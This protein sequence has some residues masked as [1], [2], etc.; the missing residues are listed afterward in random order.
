MNFPWTR[1]AWALL[2]IIAA[3]GWI[4]TGCNSS[5]TEVT[6]KTSKYEVADAEG[7]SSTSAS[8][9]NAGSNPGVGGSGAAAGS[10]ADG[11]A[12]SGIG[13][14]GDGSTPMKPPTTPPVA[15]SPQPP[16]DDSP[17]GLLGY[18]DQLNAQRPTSAP[19]FQSIQNKVIAAADKV[20]AGTATDEQ[21]ITAANMKVVALT[22][23]ANAPFVTPE[24]N[25]DARSRLS[26]F[27]DELKASES[28]GLTKFG[29]RLA[30]ASKMDE[31]QNGADVDPESVIEDLRE[32]LAEEEKDARL[33]S[34]GTTVAQLLDQNDHSE[35]AVQVYNMLAETFA[36]SEDPQ[37]KQ[38]SQGLREIARLTEA[39]LS[40]LLA[41][42]YDGQADAVGPLMVKALELLNADD[43]GTTT[44]SVFQG[45]GPNL[46]VMN[47]AA[48]KELYDAIGQAFAD[49][50]DEE[51]AAQAREL[52][53]KYQKRS[54]LVGQPFQVEGVTLDGQPFDWNQ[55]RGKVVLVDF[56]ATWC[57]PCLAEIPNIKEN[58]E[59]YGEHGFAVVGVNLD[60]DTDRL[61]QFL[62]YQ[63]LPWPSVISSDP[64]ARGWE[65]PMVEQSGVIAIPF[66][67]LVDGEGKVI[68]LNTRGDAL[69][70]KLAE[71]FPGVA[72][73]GT[74]ASGDGSAAAPTPPAS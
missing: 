56:W 27:T 58:L 45:L 41:P 29:T 42:V 24:T 52:V 61:Q 10:R 28:E 35:Q 49:H 57:T 4:A 18:I 21:Q 23:L 11:Q 3:S 60:E 5:S 31:M 15:T 53:E 48:A 74:P 43:A 7:S 2:A 1:P 34:L 16:S 39:N 20:I 19:E 73:T 59:R 37:L 66:L 67:V 33:L 46:E 17:A 38:A 32:F 63:K 30:F 70:K 55:Y 6:S 68:A 25:A 22:Q 54:S 14:A 36:N 26:G 8:P 69:D 9:E 13:R 50:P 12:P 51:L 71:L 44:F 62:D 47:P 64:E 72:A 40:E 65:H